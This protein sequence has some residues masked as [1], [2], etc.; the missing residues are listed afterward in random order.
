MSSSTVYPQ[1][2][3]H[4]PDWETLHHLHPWDWK[5]LK[6]KR[7]FPLSYKLIFYWIKPEM[8][9]YNTAL[10]P[11]CVFLFAHH[12]AL[13]RRYTS[14]GLFCLAAVVFRQF[15]DTTKLPLLFYLFLRRQES[16]R[17]GKMPYPRQ[18]CVLKEENLITKTY[19]NFFF[20]NWKVLLSKFN[21]V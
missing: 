12:K 3:K 14:V 8:R 16:T 4:E 2:K 20:I 19:F 6:G 11:R 9:T 5:C 7:D 13:P 21:V 10:Q 15:K 18:V 17:P 1:G